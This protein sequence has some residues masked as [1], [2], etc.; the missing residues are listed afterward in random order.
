MLEPPPSEVLVDR[1]SAKFAAWYELPFF[2]EAYSSGKTV[3]FGH[4]GIRTKDGRWNNMPN[5]GTSYRDYTGDWA[6]G[7][8]WLG[9][10]S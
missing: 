3:Y 8:S 1:P 2:M 4:N 6:T 9:A 7:E 10:M 5:F